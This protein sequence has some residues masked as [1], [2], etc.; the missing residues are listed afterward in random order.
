MNPA[1]L[2]RL[3]ALLAV[4]LALFYLAWWWHFGA[5]TR[6]LALTVVALAVVP[7]L[8]LAPWLWKANRFGTSLAGFILPFHFAFAVMELV[9]NPGVRGWLAVQTFLSFV[10]LVGIMASL[11]Q[12]DV[13]AR[14]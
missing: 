14:D 5:S 10:L 4:V 1:R 9:A 8:L 11:R 3:N 2:P 12:V 7:L 13:T 6:P